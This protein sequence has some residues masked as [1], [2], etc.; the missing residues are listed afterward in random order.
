MAVVADESAVLQPLSGVG[1]AGGRPVLPRLR[2]RGTY[3]RT[4]LPTAIAFAGEVAAA[5]AGADLAAEIEAFPVLRIRAP[6]RSRSAA[7]DARVRR[8]C[9]LRQTQTQDRKTRNSSPHLRKNTSAR[10]RAK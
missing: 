4:M 5:A 6:G 7:Q 3:S 10:R 2:S 8:Q 9:R 1:L